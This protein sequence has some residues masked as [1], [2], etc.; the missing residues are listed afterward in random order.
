MSRDSRG[1][2]CRFGAV[3][4]WRVQIEH[5]EHPA[6]QGELTAEAEAGQTPSPQKLNFWDAHI[7]PENVDRVLA[8]MLGQNLAF[9]DCSLQSHKNCQLPQAVF[10]CIEIRCLMILGTDFTA[11]LESRST[12]GHTSRSRLFLQSFDDFR[13]RQNLSKDG[14]KPGCF[15]KT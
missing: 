13:S 11:C 9:A 1:F 14:S 6:T 2:M 5:I 7:G 15:P 12:A 10:S 8:R 3:L 4:L